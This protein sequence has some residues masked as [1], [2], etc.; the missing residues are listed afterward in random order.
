MFD[1]DDV[2]TRK[3]NDFIKGLKKRDKYDK[4]SFCEDNEVPLLRENN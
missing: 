4:E 2:I 3:G 1:K